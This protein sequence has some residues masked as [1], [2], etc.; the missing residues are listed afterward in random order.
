MNRFEKLALVAVIVVTLRYVRGP[1]DF[2]YDY[3]RKQVPEGMVSIGIAGW[4]IA[5]YG[6][7]AIAVLFWRWAKRVRSPWIV[8]LLFLP[9]AIALLATGDTLMLLVIEDPDFEATIGAPEMAATLLF[10]VA[11]GGYL[12]ALIARRVSKSSQTENVS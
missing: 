1:G 9:C 11:V 5:S 7:I 4:A 6:P 8:H 10:L 12:A 3:Y 2:V